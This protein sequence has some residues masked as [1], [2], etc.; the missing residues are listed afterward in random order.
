MMKMM[1]AIYMYIDMYAERCGLWNMLMNMILTNVEYMYAERC[2][3]YRH[4]D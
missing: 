1:I 2:D 4:A 3:C